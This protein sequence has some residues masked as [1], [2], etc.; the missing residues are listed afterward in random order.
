LILGFVEGAA[1]FEPFDSA[2]APT[3][4]SDGV[5]LLLVP[6]TMNPDPILAS[7]DPARGQLNLLMRRPSPL[8][9]TVSDEPVILGGRHPGDGRLE[10]MPAWPWGHS[11]DMERAT[12]MSES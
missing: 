8:P 7:R 5:R 12:L 6:A 11:V 4:I 10:R 9:C 3:A 2:V 1:F